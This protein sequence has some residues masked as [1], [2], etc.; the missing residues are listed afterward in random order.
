MYEN[1]YAMIS[2]S[3]K[4]DYV[5]ELSNQL[6]HEKLQSWTYSYVL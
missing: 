5:L 6:A 2:A 1:I 3:A 4:S